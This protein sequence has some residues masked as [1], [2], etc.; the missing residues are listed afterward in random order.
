MTAGVSCPACDRSALTSVSEDAM[1]KCSHCGQRT[2]IVA[3]AH[4]Y[5]EDLA[6][7]DL[8]CSDIAETLLMIVRDD[9]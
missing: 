4:E 7:S 2:H 5:L 8:P 1:Y 6:A 9:G 3:A